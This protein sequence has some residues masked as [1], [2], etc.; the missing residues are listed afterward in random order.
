MLLCC[1][2][3]RPDPNIKEEVAAWLQR[4]PDFRQS[5]KTHLETVDHMTEAAIEDCQRFIKEL[6]DQ[7]QSRED[8]AEQYIGILMQH[9]RSILV[10]LEDAEVQE[11]QAQ[12]A[13]QQADATQP[14]QQQDVQQEQRAADALDAPPGQTA[15]AGAGAAEIAVGGAASPAVADEQQQQQQQQQP[16]QKDVEMTDAPVQ[17][18]AQPAAAHG[19]QQQQQQG[20]EQAGSSAQQPGAAQDAVRTA[21]GP[22][23]ARPLRPQLD[24]SA[25]DGVKQQ[26][27]EPQQQS[28]TTAGVDV[29]TG[30][31][32]LPF[33]GGPLLGGWGVGQWSSQPLGPAAMPWLKQVREAACAPGWGGQMSCLMRHSRTGAAACAAINFR[34]REHVFS[35]VW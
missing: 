12:L 2:L 32:E 26:E 1:L 21:M 3:F 31:G 22:P 11:K 16:D 27:D 14:K 34:Q 8:Y 35:G 17:P 7:R 28:D 13:Q 24:G 29:G 10:K 30:A 9:G 18:A 19:Q 6:E 23:P 33:P 15:A 20:P 5:L 4:L 25:V